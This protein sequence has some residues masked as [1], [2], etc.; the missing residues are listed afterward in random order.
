MSNIL[1]SIFFKSQH[2]SSYKWH[3][4]ASGLAFFGQTGITIQ[5]GL[6]AAI[7]ALILSLIL[8]LILSL[9]VSQFTGINQVGHWQGIGPALTN[10]SL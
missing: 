6:I 9:S 3:L 2:F 4:H 10:M 1:Y 5:A 8:T 7:L